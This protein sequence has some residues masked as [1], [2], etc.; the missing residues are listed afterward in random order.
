MA[1]H[2]NRGWLRR[3]SSILQHYLA[4][5]KDWPLFEAA[6]L[7]LALA[8]LFEARLAPSGLRSGTGLTANARARA[9]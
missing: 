3:R 9:G 6:H 2:L 1:D 8:R 7:I 5:E 4:G